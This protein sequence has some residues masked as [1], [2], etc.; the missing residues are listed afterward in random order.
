MATIISIMHVSSYVNALQYYG[1][2]DH[3]IVV[4]ICTHSCSAIEN[5]SIVK[6]TAGGV[7]GKKLFSPSVIVGVI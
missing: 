7:S 1:M 4:M 5:Y 6:H 3:V 2:I